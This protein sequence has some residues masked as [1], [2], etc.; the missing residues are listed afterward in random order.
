F[1]T[2]KHAWIEEKK[3]QTLAHARED[4]ARFM[5]YYNLNRPHSVLGYMSPVEYELAMQKSA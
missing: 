3:Y 1:R 5:R 2:L 4:I